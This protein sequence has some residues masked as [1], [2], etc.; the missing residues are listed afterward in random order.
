M[1][2]AKGVS[3]GYGLEVS[4][5][6]PIG[7]SVDLNRDTQALI[8]QVRQSNKEMRIGRDARGIQVGD[9][10]ALLTTLYSA[11]PYRGEREVDVLVTVTRPEGLFYMVFIAPQSEFDQIQSTFE[12]IVRSVRFF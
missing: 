11:S 1:E 7:G 8:R 4:Y 5:F 2:S 3:V 9:G 6:F 10:P 12:E